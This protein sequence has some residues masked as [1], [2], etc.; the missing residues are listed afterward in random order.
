L[1]H[2]IP[3]A[4][5]TKRKIPFQRTQRPNTQLKTR[6]LKRTIKELGNEESEQAIE[7]NDDR[8]KRIKEMKRAI[9][10]IRALKPT[11]AVPHTW[12]GLQ[13]MG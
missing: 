1:F 11:D 7:P 13:D 3:H 5:K 9:T 12:H 8:A 10:L 6:L 4:P 2:A